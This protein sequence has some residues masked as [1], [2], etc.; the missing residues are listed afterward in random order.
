M[1]LKEASERHHDFMVGDPDV[2]AKA[3]G[4]GKETNSITR[5]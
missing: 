2:L 4:H 5:K 3:A 1:E